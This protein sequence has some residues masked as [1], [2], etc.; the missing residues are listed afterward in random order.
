MKLKTILR[1]LRYGWGPEPP[2]WAQH[3][4]GMLSLL[5]LA[6]LVIVVVIR[7]FE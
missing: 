3:V 2:K 4:T 5:V 7:S 1:H 6:L